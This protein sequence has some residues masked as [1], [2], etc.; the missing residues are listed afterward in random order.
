MESTDFF[1]G[2]ADPRVVGRTT[3]LLCDILLLSLCAVI[4]GA[5]DFEDIESFIEF[6]SF[7]RLQPPLCAIFVQK[8]S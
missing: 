5:D 8:L 1:S 6:F 7:H 4:C 3:H 2:I